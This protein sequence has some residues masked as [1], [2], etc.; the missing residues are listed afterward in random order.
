MSMFRVALL[1]TAVVFMLPPSP[2]RAAGSRTDDSI[3]VQYLGGTLKTIPADSF[4]TLNLNDANE[5]RFHY[6]TS[7]YRLAY[8]QIT[9]TEVTQPNNRGHW[10]VHIPHLKRFQ[11]LVIGYRDVNGTE[12]TLNFQVNSR[13]AESAAE[14]INT[15]RHT[16]EAVNAD[17]TLWW[18][19]RYWKTPRNSSQSQWD[20][21][22]APGAVA[23][24]TAGTK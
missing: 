15:H 7:V 20:Q 1:T 5:L 23:L 12:N 13:V 3:E 11:T 2:A 6:G 18:G 24:G 21:K 17:P 4:G 22:S 8:A 16:A 10:L 14:T 9:E 19:D